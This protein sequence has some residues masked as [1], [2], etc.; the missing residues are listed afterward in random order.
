MSC[1]LRSD[2][3]QDITLIER[4]G[5]DSIN[6]DASV[7]PSPLGQIAR[8]LRLKSGVNTEITIGLGDLRPVSVPPN[9][10]AIGKP[11]VASSVADDSPAA[12]AVDGD[13][14]TRWSSAYSD[15]E[16]I[17]VDLGSVKHLTGVKLSWEA[18]FGKS[19][20]IQVS[21]DA[22]SWTDV[23]STTS[24]VGG[25]EQISFV[26]SGRYVRML[27]VQRA[28]TYGYSLWEFEVYGGV[29]KI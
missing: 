12:N 26:A 22:S 19:Y 16:W 2:V 23:Y 4:S 17:Y 13:A 6:T 3:D 8:M 20:K 5:I 24:G 18:A 1:T 29:A 10:L 27:G 7:S 9:N 25:V 11:V 14:N 15:N 21:N 28:T